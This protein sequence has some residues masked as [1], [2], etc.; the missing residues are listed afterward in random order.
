MNNKNVLIINSYPILPVFNG[1][2]KVIYEY[3][4]ILKKCGCRLSFCISSEA[5][6][7]DEMISFFEG[8]IYVYH[9]PLYKK[10]SPFNIYNKIHDKLQKK[11]PK[12]YNKIDDLF[13]FGFDEYVEELHNENNYDICIVNY[14]TL[15]KVYEKST[16]KKKAIYTHDAFTYKTELLKLN[17]FWFNLKPNE[18]AKGIRRATDIISIQE[19]E[20]NL[21]H[22]YSPNANLYTVYSSF[23][24]NK[25]PLSYNNNILFIAGKNE[26]NFN[27]ITYFIENVFSNVLRM[28]SNAKLL[29]AGQICDLL[30]QYS[31]CTH[32]ELKGIIKD[33]DEFYALGD[34][35]INPV[36]QG[37]GLKVKTFEALSYGKITIVHEHSTDGIFK[38]EIAPLLVAHDAEQY[39]DLINDVLNSKDIRDNYHENAIAY[40]EEL[41][42]YVYT[43]YYNL[44]N[45]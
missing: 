6:I 4:K 28:H 32:I 12:K 44:T 23:S 14:I 2:C 39:A 10:I 36:Y 35:V 15:S 1:A 8:R 13:P 45:K 37:T 7:S 20:S 33:I 5:S 26:V 16:I 41:N 42:K 38:K 22:Y 11:I 27:G 3:C 34:I 24:I 25:Q 18:E 19:N 31:S 29:I 17:N 30:Q 9:K 21:F 43:Q 40:M